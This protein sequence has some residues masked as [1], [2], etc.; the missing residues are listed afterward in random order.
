MKHRRTGCPAL[1]LLALAACAPTAAPGPAEELAGWT[2]DA[3]GDLNAFFD[4][5]AAEKIALASAHRG[6]PA[7]GYP[8]NALE[9]LKRTQSRIPALLEV[10]LAA[11]ADG[12][13]FLLHDATLERTTTGTGE[14]AAR[15]W[16]EIE[17]L[18]LKDADGAATDFAPPRFEEVLAWAAPRTILVLDIKQ[19]VSYEAVA[20]AIEDQHTEDRVILIATTVPQ[21]KKLRGLLPAT[22]IS[23]DIDSMSDLNHAVAAG[24]PADRLLGFTGTAEPRPR[25]FDALSGR[26][27]EIVFGTLGY[28]NSIDMAIAASRDDSQYADI[29][30]MGVDLIATDRPEAAHAA[31][32]AAG[33]GA[34]GGLCGV[35]KH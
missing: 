14:A 26:H 19:G 27:V 2:I 21:A 18:R 31:L 24:V 3:K 29:A 15:P 35:E 4:C 8:E 28:E 30:A 13:L 32:A 12:V 34:R 11:S 17:N 20:A 6:G 7:P 25:L 5:L 23:L 33:R 22:M 1:A 16:A 10:D 9:T